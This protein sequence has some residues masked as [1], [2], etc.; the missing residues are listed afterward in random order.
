MFEEVVPLTAVYSHVPEEKIDLSERNVFVSLTSFVVIGCCPVGI[1]D[2]KKP[3]HSGSS[4]IYGNIRVNNP[5]QLI[6]IK[7][8][9][10]EFFVKM[11]FVYKPAVWSRCVWHECSAA[12]CIRSTNLL[13]N[14]AKFDGNFSR[15]ARI[16][17]AGISANISWTLE[18]LS[19]QNWSQNDSSLD[20]ICFKYEDETNEFNRKMKSIPDYE[21]LIEQ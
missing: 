9:W 6:T 21:K 16:S 13:H 19:D 20:S 7:C 12:D 15:N 18:I 4:N 1:S 11:F 3:R 14:V 17:A 8:R 2:Q 10:I 5:T